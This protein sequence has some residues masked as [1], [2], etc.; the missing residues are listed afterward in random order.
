MMEKKKRRGE[1]Y[2]SRD[3]KRR[4]EGDFGGFVGRLKAKQKLHS[5]TT[6]PS[7]NSVLRPLTH[8]TNGE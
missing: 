4:I 3:Y 2:E 7:T 5:L 6:A 8:K 1:K